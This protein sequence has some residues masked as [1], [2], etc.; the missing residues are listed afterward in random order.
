M[1]QSYQYQKLSNESTIRLIRLERDLVDNQIAC[2]IRHADCSYADT[3]YDA[4]SYV[5]GNSES[6]RKIRIKDETAPEWSVLELHE[7]LWVFLDNFWRRKT[8]DR[9][10]WTDRICL[11][12]VDQHEMGQ[13]IP[14]VAQIYNDAERVLAWLGLTVSQGEALRLAYEYERYNRSNTVD[15]ETVDASLRNDFPRETLEAAIDVR[16]APYWGR[17]WVVQEILSAKQ[18]ICLVGNLEVAFWT[19]TRVV[20]LP[21]EHHAKTWLWLNAWKTIGGTS[22]S[23]AEAKGKRETRMK[24]LDLWELL[25]SVT[26]DRNNYASTRVH[27]R[28]Y[29]ILGLAESVE[30]GSSPAL[31]IR[32]A[33]YDELP[34]YVFIDATI[35]SYPEWERP[36][37][38]KLEWGTQDWDR[39]PPHYVTALRLLLDVWRLPEQVGMIDIFAIFEEYVQC[40]R[41]SSRHKQLVGLLLQTCDA[42]FSTFHQAGTSTPMS[43]STPESS[44]FSEYEGFHRILLHNLYCDYLRPSID[45]KRTAQHNA[46]ILGI[47]LVLGTSDEKQAMQIWAY[48]NARR[49]HLMSQTREKWRC[50]AHLPSQQPPACVKDPDC[51]S[52]YGRIEAAVSFSTTRL[53]SHVTRPCSGAHGCDE[54]TMVF[55]IPEAGL[56]MGLRRN[57]FSVR[58]SSPVG[59][60]EGHS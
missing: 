48:W 49:G 37:W 59:S 56:R 17:V 16:N 38:D 29:G 5:W 7:S 27:D 40:N 18:V 3:V 26:V 6:T 10:I 8:F 9:W 4:L 58:L 14:L 44:G 57:T 21:Q 60:L 24:T 2:I 42:L 45:F 36:I 11:N 32:T 43:H 41:T 31:L 30:G 25:I 28:I 55:E 13:Q 46:A 35:E 1:S 19:L 23:Y 51:S 34:V 52:E 53:N 39:D 20:G 15:F 54:T 12:Q 50:C 33:V 22:S 47:A